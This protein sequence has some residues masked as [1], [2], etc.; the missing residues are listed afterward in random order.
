[1]NERMAD[2]LAKAL[3]HNDELSSQL[4][5]AKAVLIIAHEKLIDLNEKLRAAQQ[6]ITIAKIDH[7]TAATVADHIPESEFDL[8]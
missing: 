5:D 4:T 3:A 2:D 6:K 7:L 8:G 1:M